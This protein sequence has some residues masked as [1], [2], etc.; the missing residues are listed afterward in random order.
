MAELENDS[1]TQRLYLTEAA[2]HIK[3]FTSKFLVTY[4]IARDYLLLIVRDGYNITVY[5]DKFK[6]TISLMRLLI[7]VMESQDPQ[8]FSRSNFKRIQTAFLLK[9]IITVQGL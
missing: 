9:Q 7:I 8:L 4:A 1:P 2:V 5:D 6:N 3:L